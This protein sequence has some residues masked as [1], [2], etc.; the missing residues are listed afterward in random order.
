MS[1]FGGSNT[2]LSYGSYNQHQ[3]PTGSR[4]AHQQIPALPTTGEPSTSSPNAAATAAAVVAQQQQQHHHHHQQQQHQQLQQQQQQQQQQQHQQQQHQQQ[5]Q[6]HQQK[7]HQGLQ[8]GHLQAN[9]STQIGPPSPSAIKQAI[10]QDDSS[11]KKK[12]RRN[13]PGQK[14]GAKKKSWVWSWFVQDSSDPNIAACD[15]CGKIIIRLAS[16]KGSPKKLSEHLKT[17]KL[18]KESINYSRPIP[19]DGFG[20]TYT[21]NGEPLTYSVQFE[22]A[23]QQA[24]SQPQNPTSNPSSSDNHHSPVAS[25]SSINARLNTFGVQQGFDNGFRS[26]QMKRKEAYSQINSRR[27]VSADFDNTPYSAMKFHKHLLKFLTENKLAIS[28]IKSNSF[29]QLVYDLRSDSI[30]DLME[31]ASLYSGLLEVSRYDP[32]NVTDDVGVNALA[33]VVEKSSNISLGSRNNLAEP[34]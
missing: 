14:F 13:R 27:Y 16:D 3:L 8:S 26:E 23:Q 25:N 32:S 15:Y 29:Q 11:N 17:H 19:I 2:P 9:S 33:S 24:M 28:V 21:S 12:E 4:A 6:Q 5:Q 10:A 18:T 22:E 20:N 34:N 7:Q 1:Y 30:N 31:L